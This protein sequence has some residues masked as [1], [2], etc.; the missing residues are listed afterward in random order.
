MRKPFS[1]VQQRQSLLATHMKGNR[2]LNSGSGSMWV[3]LKSRTLLLAKN[4]DDSKFKPSHGCTQRES[5]KFKVLWIDQSSLTRKHTSFSP[6]AYHIPSRPVPM[7]LWV[8]FTPFAAVL[9]FLSLFCGSPGWC[10]KKL[11][12]SGFHCLFFLL[13]I[14]FSCY[15]PGNDIEGYFSFYIHGAET[16]VHSFC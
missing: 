7:P 4:Y 13:R 6:F 14:M 3:K 10:A 5:T 12:Q 1:Q 8:S 16:H 2:L 11:L 15:H 9:L